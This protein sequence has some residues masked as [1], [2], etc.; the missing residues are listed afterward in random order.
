[1]IV[2]KPENKHDHLNAENEYVTKSLAHTDESSK[3]KIYKEIMQNKKMMLCSLQIISK[4]LVLYCYEEGKE[5][6]IYG[7]KKG[8]LEEKKKRRN[9]LNGKRTQKAIVLFKQSSTK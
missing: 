6:P 9:L 5:Y 2:T 8:T 7:R 3:Q 1:M 4:L